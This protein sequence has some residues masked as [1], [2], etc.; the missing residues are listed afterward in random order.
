MSAATIGPTPYTSVTVVPDA[1][2]AIAD[3][4]LEALELVVDAAHIGEQLERRC[5]LRSTSTSV[6]AV[7]SRAAPDRP[8]CARAAAGNPPGISRH[9]TAWSRQIARV[10]E[11]GQVVVALRQQPQHRGVVHRPRPDAAAG[12]AT[13]RSPPSGRRG[14][15][16]CRCGPSPAAAP[17]PTASAARRRRAR[18]PRRAAGPTTRPSPPA[19]SIAH[20]RGS[21]GAA[22][23]NSRSRCRRSA[24]TRSS[25][26]SC[27]VSSSTAAVCD[28][29]CGSIPMM[30]TTS[31]SDLPEWVMPRRA[32]LMRV[33]CSPL[34]SHAAART[35]R[36]ATSL[37]SQ[38]ERRQGILETTHRP[39]NAT[40]N[41]QRRASDP[42]S[43]QYAW[44][45][46]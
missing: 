31:S 33:D 15:R 45:A 36:A 25:P 29:L 10:R 38:P 7:E 3:A 2:T 8:A 21:N 11:R 22:N 24:A 46:G 42:Q 30:N 9:N 40:S 44:L 39:S 18:R 20:V 12:G 13:R 5:A 34:S 17:A 28:P 1:A 41:P 6:G 27:F 26:T 19:P 43:G 4:L 37:G 32:V 23:R 16:S 14:G 35:R